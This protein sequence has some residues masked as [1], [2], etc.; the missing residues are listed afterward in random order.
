M[1]SQ[2]TASNQWRCLLLLSIP[3]IV[4]WKQ[5][6]NLNCMT[7]P[8]QKLWGVKCG[9]WGREKLLPTRQKILLW[10]IILV[11]LSIQKKLISTGDISTDL[12]RCEKLCFYPTRLHFS[13]WKTFVRS[14]WSWQPPWIELT[15][16]VDVT[17][18]NIQWNS[19]GGS[20]D[21]LLKIRHT[22]LLG[23]FLS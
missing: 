13:V 17:F 15:P 23:I 12:C 11:K 6:L 22:V 3:L 14:V 4:C 16:K 2:K 10:I 9:R 5:D 7:Q 1:N 19:S 21:I 8:V 18:R 20:W